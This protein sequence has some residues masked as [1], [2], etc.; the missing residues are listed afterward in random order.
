MLSAARLSRLDDPVLLDTVSTVLS[1]FLGLWDEPTKQALARHSTETLSHA[2]LQDEIVYLRAFTIVFALGRELGDGRIKT[3][4]L[5]RFY[6]RAGALVPNGEG[7]LTR[8]SDYTAAIEA[9]GPEEVGVQ[10][11]RVFAQQLGQ[12]GNQDIRNLG[13]S[14]FLALEGVLSRF[15]LDATAS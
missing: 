15:L 1:G 7:F 9:A 3:A 5:D 8:A 4:L 13:A 14:Q 11:G 10:V 2:T 6:G 12:P